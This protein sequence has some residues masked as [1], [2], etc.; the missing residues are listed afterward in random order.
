MNLPEILW[1]WSTSLTCRAGE[2]IQRRC[3]VCSGQ[4]FKD[5]K[6]HPG[7]GEETIMPRKCQVTGKKAMTG[8]NVSH[9][10]NKTKRRFE[11]NLQSHRFFVPGEGRWI[12]L[13]VT[14]RG[15]KTID[16]LGIETVLA[17]MR[18]NGEKV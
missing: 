18:A 17:K 8:N 5:S 7:S 16:K 6:H 4:A 13:R 2:Q 15:I 1:Q 14:P 12:R 10:N 9:A 3:P 11:P